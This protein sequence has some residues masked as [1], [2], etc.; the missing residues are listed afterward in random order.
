MNDPHALA[1]EKLT[2]SGEYERLSEQ[3]S[4]IDI[5]RPAI[6]IEI[7]KDCKSDKEADMKWDMTEMGK[8]EIKIRA[9]LKWID[10]RTSA[11]SSMLR[12]LETEWRNSGGGY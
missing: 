1:E 7:K 10:K 4:E 2:I 11:I 6:W 9:R 8:E 3:L 12:V 5:L